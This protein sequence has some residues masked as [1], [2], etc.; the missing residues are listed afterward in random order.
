MFVACEQGGQSVLLLVGEEVSA[1]V[2]RAACGVERVVLA[3]AVSVD[4]LLDA[5]SALVEGIA[6]QA[7]HV[8]GIHHRDC[9][10]KLFGGGG[11]EAG[12]P[13]HRDDLHGLTPRLGALG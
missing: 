10:G 4:G 11:L 12:E 9:V 1:G 7:D 3:A 6:G 8:E 13:V 2:Q 5:P